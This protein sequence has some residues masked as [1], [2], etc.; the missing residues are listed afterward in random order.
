MSH[1]Q[2]INKNSAP[3]GR[4]RAGTISG[5]ISGEHDGPRKSDCRKPRTPLDHYVKNPM[6]TTVIPNKQ[7][8]VILREALYRIRVLESKA[9]STPTSAPASHDLPSTP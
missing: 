2:F 7:V 3:S 6:L 1:G 5:A 9:A 4:L 8:R